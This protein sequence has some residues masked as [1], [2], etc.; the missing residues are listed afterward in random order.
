MRRG[1]YRGPSRSSAAEGGEQGFWPSYADM[2]SAVALILF[3]LML[4]SYIQ[5][6]ITGNDL[7]N[8]QELLDDTRAQ[9]AD[10]QLELNSLSDELK[11]RQEQLDEYAIRIDDQT[12]TISAQEL[13]ISDQQIYLAAANDEILALRSQMQTVAVL[14]LSILEQIKESIVDVMGD[15]SKVSIGDNGNIILNEGIFF[16]LGS[17][18]IK[19]ESEKVL[20]ELIEVFADFLKDAENAKY[21]DSIV[22]SGHTDITGNAD[23]NRLL[24]TDRANSV[25]NYLLS[26]KNAVLESYAPYFC[27]AGYGATRPVASNYTEEGRASNRRIEI[28]MIL[29][30][31]TVLDIVEQYL[32]IEVPDSRLRPN[33]AASSED[34]YNPTPVVSPTPVPAPTP[35]RFSFFGN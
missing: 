20:N 31:D 23:E 30:D 33:M 18:E 3:F 19:P 6:L 26:G 22:I 29:K 4:I 25:L 2:M 7:Q 13:L 32:A 21:V 27:A 35:G 12:N 8:T 11:R 24:S 10:A 1:G 15:E 5:N 34:P 17:A 14:R 28:S 9:V 16:D